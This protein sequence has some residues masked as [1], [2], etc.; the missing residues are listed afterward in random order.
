MYKKDFILIGSIIGLHGLKGYIKV[1]SFLENPKDIFNFDEYFIN[2]LSFSLLLLKFN[3]KSV[4]I[5][6]L[7]GI[8]S[9]EKAK[10]FVNKNIFIR[11]SSLPE[12]EKDE[13]YL[14]DLIGF[15]VELECGLHLGEL[16]NFY[17]FG[18]GLIIGVNIVQEEKMLPFSE[19]FII[20]INQDLK[21]ITLSSSIKK[22]ID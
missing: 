8:N 14:N 11:R 22:L 7:D 17:D 16:V 4:F 19:N 6:E 21:V 15:N 18:A 13:I 3:K 2:K 10:E 12:I 20:N 1:K 5:C 9:L